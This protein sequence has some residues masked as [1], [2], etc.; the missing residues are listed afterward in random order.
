MALVYKLI[1]LL[2]GIIVL[3]VILMLGASELGGEIVTLLRPEQDGSVKEVRLWIVDAGNKSWVEHGD[4]ESYWQKQLSDQ[5]DISLIRDG[6]Q[7][8]Y[9]AVPDLSAHDYYHRLRRE[10]YGIADKIVDIG[11]FGLQDKDTCMG[12]PVRLIAK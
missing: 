1:S 2:A 5:A 7:K 11:S 9:T 6:E 4:N 12:V 10:K 8:K 3:Y